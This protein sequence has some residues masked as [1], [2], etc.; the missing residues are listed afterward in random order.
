MRDR[1]PSRPANSARDNAPDNDR[2][3]IGPPSTREGR[4]RP[5]ICDFPSGFW[6]KILTWKAR[7]RNPAPLRLPC[8]LPLKRKMAQAALLAGGLDHP[9][10]PDRYYVDPPHLSLATLQRLRQ[11]ARLLVGEPPCPP[12]DPNGPGKPVEGGKRFRPAAFRL[13]FRRGSSPSG[14]GETPSE[15]AARVR[16]LRKMAFAKARFCE[17]KD[18]PASPARRLEARHAFGR[19]V[20][21]QGASRLPKATRFRRDPSLDR[22]ASCNM[23]A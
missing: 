5:S 15:F 18:R 3:P 1:R 9:R 19:V 8:R 16:Q 6:C 22:P 7:N 17:A 21:S 4:Q 12:V 13:A 14:L 20:R 11:R 23:T 10:R 2:P